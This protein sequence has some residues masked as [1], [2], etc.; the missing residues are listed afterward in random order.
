MAARTSR[1]RAVRSCIPRLWL[2]ALAHGLFRIVPG[3]IAAIIKEVLP[4]EL[5]VSLEAQAAVNTCLDGTACTVTEPCR[6]R[7]AVHA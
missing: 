1:F 4:S 3:T 7:A 5:K 2:L 6:S